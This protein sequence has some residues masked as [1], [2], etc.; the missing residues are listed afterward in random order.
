[1]KKPILVA[2]LALT[3]GGC[4]GSDVAVTPSTST[5]VVQVNQVLLR[6]VTTFVKSFRISGYAGGSLVFG[7]VDVLKQA[8][9]RVDKVPTNVDTL[10]IEYISSTGAVIGRY[11]TP[12]SITAGGTYVIDD[13]D[14]VSVAPPAIAGTIS[15]PTAPLGA[16]PL[17]L[18]QGDFNGDGILDMACANNGSQDVS[19]LLGNGQGGFVPAGTY[20]SG[21]QT[22]GI[23][24]G[25]LTGDGH[26]DIVASNYG[27]ELDANRGF[28][29]YY[30]GRGDGTF[31]SKIEIPVGDGPIGVVLADLDGDG[32]DDIANTNYREDTI[33]ILFSHGDGTFSAPDFVRTAVR[34][35]NLNFGDLDGDGDLDLAVADEGLTLIPGVPGGITILNNQGAGHFV[36]SGD[37]PAGV[38]SHNVQIADLNGDG[39]QDLAVANYGSNQVSILIGR[40]NRSFEAPVQLSTPPVPLCSIV[41]D[42]NQDGIPDLATATF[43]ESKI[44][45][46]TGY[47]DGTFSPAATLAV[48]Q[49]PFFVLTGDYNRDG[50]PDYATA[51]SGSDNLSVLLGQ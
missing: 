13:P 20:A 34:P 24:V 41:G 48:G 50:I 17:A 7:P 23:A 12:A 36:F 27:S 31:D 28:L 16:R 6:G 33:S 29:T 10:V 22:F 40:G 37:Y 26:L 32:R 51:N 46:F 8:T 14:W 18:A 42:Y 38:N 15:Q 11:E 2:L 49:G 21:Q 45:V 4:G 5:G 1:M 35:R 47:G 44:A 43:E 9:V 30:R 39:E 25:D 19:V 3:L